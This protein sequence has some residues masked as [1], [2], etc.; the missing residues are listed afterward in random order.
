MNKILL[1]LLSVMTCFVCILTIA[2][3]T[4]AFAQEKKTEVTEGDED[5]ALIAARKR[6]GPNKATA[7]VGEGKIFILAGKPEIEKDSGY[8]KVDSLKTGEI[9]VMTLGQAV[10]FSTTENLKFGSLMI[11]KENV[12]PNYPGVYSVWMKKTASGWNFVFNSKPDIWST[13]HKDKFDVGETPATYKVLDE[14]VKT[15]KVEM[16]ADNG[17]GSFSIAWG[18][19]QWSTNFSIEP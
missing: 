6:Y 12:A 19:H 3:T 5:A 2:P 15:V 8:P 13:M 10:K 14:P 4:T 1:Q 18:K 7:E 17:K 11:K 16:N 9:V